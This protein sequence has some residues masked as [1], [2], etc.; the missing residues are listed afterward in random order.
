[1]AHG[2]LSLWTVAIGLGLGGAL[3]GGCKKTAHVRDTTPTL[4]EEL[5]P[6]LVRFEDVPVE[7]TR[8]GKRP[9]VLF[10]MSSEE[11]EA[12]L[13]VSDVRAS[14]AGFDDREMVLVEVYETGISR[15]EHRPMSPESARE[16]HRMY[17]AS[18]WPVE[19]VLVDKDGGVKRRVARAVEL[20]GLFDQID[21]TPVRQREVYERGRTDPGG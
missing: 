17:R 18:K 13:L 1:M 21:A 11:P 4:P 8:A 6:V 14:R 19:V 5:D 15:Y 20:G 16:W 9:L 2:P 7:E 12:A 10:A 3:G